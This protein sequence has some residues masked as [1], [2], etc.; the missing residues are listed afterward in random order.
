MLYSWSKDLTLR[1]TYSDTSIYLF[2]NI[3]SEWFAY[4]QL[5]ILCH[6]SFSVDCREMDTSL[7]V[8][9]AGERTFNESIK[10]VLSIVTN[11]LGFE[12]LLIIMLNSHNYHHLG[13]L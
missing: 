12:K 7:F 1:D 6:C 4:T 11:T 10:K 5:D 8:I 3:K 13:T 9:S 2:L